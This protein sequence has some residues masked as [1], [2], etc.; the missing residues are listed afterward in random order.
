[1]AADKFNYNKID[2]TIDNINTVKKT[3]TNRNTERT[4]NNN[5]HKFS[6]IFGWFKS[7][8]CDNGTTY[9]TIKGKCV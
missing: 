6:S 9:D 8:C 7:D 4:F 2:K 1:M 3:T 5:S